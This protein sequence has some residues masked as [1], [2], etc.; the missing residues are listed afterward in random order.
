MWGGSGWWPGDA[1]ALSVAEGGAPFLQP[2]VPGIGGN[3]KRRRTAPA[4][5]QAL[6]SPPTAPMKAPFTHH[7]TRRS[8]TLAP[9]QSRQSLAA[10][11]QRH[12]LPPRN[13]MLGPSNAIVRAA[14]SPDADQPFARRQPDTRWANLLFCYK[15]RLYNRMPVL[16]FLFFN[17][18]PARYQPDSAIRQTPDAVPVRAK[19]FLSSGRV[20]MLSLIAGSVPASLVAD[21]SPPAAGAVHHQRPKK[22]SPSFPSEAQNFPV[23]LQIVTAHPLEP[24]EVRA[25]DD[26]WTRKLV[27]S[28]N[29]VRSE[30]FPL[31]NICRKLGASAIAGAGLRVLAAEA[32]A[33]GTQDDAAR[34]WSTIWDLVYRVYESRDMSGSEDRFLRDGLCRSLHNHRRDKTPSGAQEA[35]AVV[36]IRGENLLQQQLAPRD[37]L[38]EKRLAMALEKADLVHHTRRLA[39]SKRCDG[40]TIGDPVVAA[41]LVLPPSG[42]DP[43]RQRLDLGRPLLLVPSPLLGGGFASLHTIIKLNLDFEW[44]IFSDRIQVARFHH[45]VLSDGLLI[46]QEANEMAT[47]NVATPGRI[48]NPLIPLAAPFVLFELGGPTP[49]TTKPKKHFQLRKAGRS[50]I[51]NDPKYGAPFLQPVVPGIGGNR[52]KRRTAPVG[53]QALASSPTAPMKAFVP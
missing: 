51:G 32:A 28:H 50:M 42:H 26:R 53:E 17:Q 14:L 24:R 23:Y 27:S 5:E 47:P 22:Q 37:G 43:C 2:V 19:P 49:Q 6:A 40:N 39:K 1:L 10:S 15:P 29:K 13:K 4:G 11:K 12:L 36:T 25:H 44:A 9:R 34:Y 31:S 52:R 45:F 16:F 38:C 3:R 48:N 46:S 20:E 7:P 41:N 33:G 18:T 30:Y 21:G 35:V 8:P